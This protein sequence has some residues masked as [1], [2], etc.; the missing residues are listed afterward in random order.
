MVAS[1]SI[2]T[3][4]KPPFEAGYIISIKDKNK[5]N[6]LIDEMPEMINTSGILNFYKDMGLETS[7]ELKRAE[8]NYKGV[9]IDSAKLMF[10]ST[11]PDSPQGQ[12]IQNMYG[13]GF[14]YRWGL[15]NDL[16]VMTIGGDSETAINTLID[17]V[18]AGVPSQTAAE[19]KSAMDL[20]PQADKAD[21]LITYNIIRLFKMITSMVPVPIPAGT[22]VIRPINRAMEITEAASIK[23]ILLPN[24]IRVNLRE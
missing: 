11:A 19:I 22:N 23:L 8:K 2:M 24:A 13:N 20:L 5:F 9:S 21:F 18:Q 1:V 16:C 12:I 7:F 10:N 17:K 14:D 3:G 4:K 15:V 6:T